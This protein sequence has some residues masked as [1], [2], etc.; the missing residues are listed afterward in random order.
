M[1]GHAHGRAHLLCI[2][3]SVPPTLSVLI[4]QTGGGALRH[5]P[6][7]SVTVCGALPAQ[8]AFLAP[9]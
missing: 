8:E 4:C 3:Y 6:H 7:D 9:P 5:H 1:G 2:T